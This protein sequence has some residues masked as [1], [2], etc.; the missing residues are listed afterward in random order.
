ML[1]FSGSTA[2]NSYFFRAKPMV[3][4]RFDTEPMMVYELLREV[5]ADDRPVAYPL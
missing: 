3:W 4:S 1:G 5:R 2:K